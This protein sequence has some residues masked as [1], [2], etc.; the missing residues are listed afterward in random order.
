M[1][2]LKAKTWGPSTRGQTVQATEASRSSAYSASHRAR[3]GKAIRQ[4]T[5][6]AAASRAAGATRSGKKPACANGL[7]RVVSVAWATAA[8]NG[9]AAAV[10][11]RI[12]AAPTAL[13]AAV[14]GP[15]GGARGTLGR[16]GVRSASAA[17]APVHPPSSAHPIETASPSSRPGS[18]NSG[19]VTSA[20]PPSATTA[21]GTQ[22]A[23]RRSRSRAVRTTGGIGCPYTPPW[24]PP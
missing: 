8:T 17:C 20:D 4:N 19:R 12:V 9:T 22:P 2:K 14:A 1:K 10:E 15:G 18:S 21:A 16:G 13:A 5:P 6:A 24:P 7:Q 23:G 3:A 11:I